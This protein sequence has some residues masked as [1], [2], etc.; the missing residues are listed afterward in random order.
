[1]N[2]QL[3]RTSARILRIAKRREFHSAIREIR[4]FG[5]FAFERV[6]TMEIKP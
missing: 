3:H 6:A 2:S 1:M 5:S 4:A